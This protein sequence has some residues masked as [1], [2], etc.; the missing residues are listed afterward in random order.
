[1]VL[2]R[3]KDLTEDL[4]NPRVITERAFKKMCETMDRFGNVGGASGIVVD[5]NNCIISGHQRWKYYM[6]RD[7]E[8]EILVQRYDSTLTKALRA[9]MNILGNLHAGD[10]DKPLLAEMMFEAGMGQSLSDQMN[11]E[12]FDEERSIELLEPKPYEKYNYILIAFRSEPE[13]NSVSSMLGLDKKREV[14]SKRK[15]ARKL[16]ARAFWYDELPVKFVPKVD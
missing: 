2:V 6:Q 7:P 8:E 1:M 15:G 14:V 5:C 16:K 9:E 11:Q 12:K 13:F 4:K 10:W 3:P